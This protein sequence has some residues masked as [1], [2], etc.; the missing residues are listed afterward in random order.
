[1]AVVGRFESVAGDTLQIAIEGTLAIGVLPTNQML[2]GATVA[3]PATT[4]PALPA[5][6]G[7]QPVILRKC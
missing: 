5:Q 4:T 2:A 6:A 3:T 1:M 7:R